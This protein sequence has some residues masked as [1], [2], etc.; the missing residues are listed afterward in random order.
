MNW[1]DVAQDWDRLRGLMNAGWTIA[2]RKT[3]RIS[4]LAEEL[5]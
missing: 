2:Y 3:R 4:W 5:L 1:T